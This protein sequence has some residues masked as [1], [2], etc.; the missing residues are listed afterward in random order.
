M[1]R[2]IL[3]SNSVLD[4]SSYTETNLTSSDTNGNIYEYSPCQNIL[5]C[6]YAGTGMITF[7]TFGACYVTAIFSYKQIFK[8]LT[9]QMYTK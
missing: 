1:F 2:V 3:Y 4:L 7:Q 8:I 9:N 5:S 6:P